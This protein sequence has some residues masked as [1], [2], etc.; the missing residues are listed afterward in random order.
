MLVLSR[1]RSCCRCS[2]SRRPWRASAAASALPLPSSASPPPR[3][4]AKR[5][6]QP[7]HVARLRPLRA[8][9][10]GLAGIFLALV[11]VTGAAVSLAL[12][13]APPR[14]LARDPARAAPAR[15]RDRHRHRPGVRL[16]ARLGDAQRLAST[17]SPALDRDRRLRSL[18]AYFVGALTKL[19]GAA[20]LAAFALLYGADR[21]LRVRRLG[22]TRRPTSATTRNVVFV[23]LLVGF[24]TKIGLLPL[25]GRLPRLLRG[26]ARRAAAT[27]V[28]RVQ[29]RLLRPLAA[30]LRD[31]RPGAAL[32]GRARFVLG[33]LSASSASST[34]SRRT[35]SSASSASRASSTRASS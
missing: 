10:D 5:E 33:G 8:R 12:A 28:D 34:R 31:A 18:A 24:G 3:G 29:R 21:Q 26:R 32:V 16:P 1:R 11:G 30:R 35:T 17:C 23:L 2:A 6:R 22:S 19:G 25:Q 7:R 4:W 20:L 9:A 15:G 14:R 27:I 13:R